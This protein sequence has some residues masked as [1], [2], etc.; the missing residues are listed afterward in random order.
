MNV[1]ITP[2]PLRGT[3]GAIGSK[4]DI[5]R[6]LICAAMSDSATEISGV[7]MSEDVRATIECVR[8]MGAKVAVS[9]DKCT[10]IPYNPA[11]NPIFDCG[12]SGST[13]RFMLPCASAV[14]G[15]GRFIGRGRLPRRPIG[16]LAAA[17]KSGGVRFSADTLPLTVTGRLTAGRYEIAGNVS[18][19]YISGL[20]MAL[21]VTKDSS[22]LHLTTPLES[23]R[24]VDMTLET[25]KLFGGEIQVNGSEYTIIGHDRLI[26]PQTARA[27]G[28]WSNAAFFLTA[29]ALGGEVTVTGLRNGSLQGDRRIIDILQNFGAKTAINDNNITVRSGSLS[30]FHIDLTHIPD[31]LPILAVA[32]SFGSGE[33][34]FTGGARLRI[35]ESDRL[36]TVAD[37][38]NALGG[39]AV[40]RS[41]GLIVSGGG[42]T[43][44]TVDGAEDHRIVMAASIAAAYCTESVTIIGAEAV[45][46]SYPEFFEHF[47]MLGGECSVL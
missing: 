4:S 36:R 25:L 22:I 27:D 14:C 17:M 12:E 10:V 34:V 35:K 8:S 32:A 15:G 42:L 18:S 37:M 43:G 45:N 20:L 31:L 38:I 33:T 41:D 7:T 26:S 19:Q 6:L 1:R 21:S 3:V 24:Y 47:K 13:L 11:E 39:R 28:D 5:H 23:A 16:E 44:G 30:G 9:E 2:H 29:A 46:K 40:E